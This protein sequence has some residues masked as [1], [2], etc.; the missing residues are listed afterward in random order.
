[1][2]FSM[3]I[4]SSL[5]KKIFMGLTGL[6]LSGFIIIHLLG[7]L[8]LL[9]PDPD[10]FNKYAHFLT[11]QTGSVIYV[12]EF[13]LAA[14][15]IIHFVYA[16]IIQIGNWLARSSRYKQVTWQRET[17][18]KS[19]GSVTMI[20]TGI[21][22]LVFVVL[23]LFHFKFGEIIYYTP[24]G[25]EYEIR[26]LYSVVYTF[27]SNFWNVLF[28]VVVMILLGFHLSHGVWSAFQSLGLYGTRFTP[29]AYGL[30]SVFAV[31]M[32]IGFIFLPVWIFIIP[33][34]TI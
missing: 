9:N 17:S 29:F 18:R 3:T 4:F 24:Q 16:I 1:M 8:T 15:F 21:I 6:M 12:A 5:G 33:G 26:D 7:N 31:I 13:M 30:G 28:Y 10:P 2:R 32:A 34:G 25:Y 14:V 20:Y 23:H 19:I 27:F 22:I 11:Q